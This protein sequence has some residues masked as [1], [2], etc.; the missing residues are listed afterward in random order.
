MKYFIFSFL[1]RLFLCKSKTFCHCS[2]RIIPHRWYNFVLH[3]H[4]KCLFKI[5]GWENCWLLTLREQCR[6]RVFENS[7][8][9]EIFGPGKDEVTRKCREL[10]NE[11]LT[12]L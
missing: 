10:H 4:L 6:L 2:C 1:T 9:R 7:V 11:V 3:F 12:D 8:L 5:R